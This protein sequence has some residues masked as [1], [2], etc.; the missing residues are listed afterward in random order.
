M[1]KLTETPAPEAIE[2]I[3]SGPAGREPKFITK[4]FVWGKYDRELEKYVHEGLVVARYDKNKDTI[5]RVA[6]V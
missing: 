1:S 5:C 2:M 4:E 6:N 3:V